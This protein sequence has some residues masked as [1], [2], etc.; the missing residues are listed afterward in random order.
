VR[1]EEQ[2]LVRLGDRIVLSE[3][4]DEDAAVREHHVGGVRGFFIALMPAAARAVNIPD[5]HELRLQE[6]SSGHL[7]HVSQFLL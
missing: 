5:R 7:R 3:M 2:Y 4:S 1:I 6:R